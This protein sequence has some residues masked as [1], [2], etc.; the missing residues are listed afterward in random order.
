MSLGGLKAVG[1]GSLIWLRLVPVVVAFA[2]GGVIGVVGGTVRARQE[3]VRAFRHPEKIPDRIL[4]RV[5]ARLGLSPDQAARV[6]EIV[7]RRHATMETLRTTAQTRQLE[8]FYAMRAEV[9]TTLT[10]AQ[11]IE[12]TALCRTIEQRFLPPLSATPGSPDGRAS[13]PPSL[14][15]RP[16]S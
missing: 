15:P 5:R 7:R 1:G 9:T 10:P 8:E 2:S 11:A 4:P 6:E 14:R 16:G 3:M 13:G 12:W